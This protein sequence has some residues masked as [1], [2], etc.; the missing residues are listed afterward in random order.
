MNWTELVHCCESPG[1]IQ[2]FTKSLFERRLQKGLCDSC[3]HAKHKV[4]ENCLK[5]NAVLFLSTWW[6]SRWS[7]QFKFIM[8][9]STFI[10]WSDT[11]SSCDE[12]YMME[13]HLWIQKT[14]TLTASYTYRCPFPYLSRKLKDIEIKWTNEIP[15]WNYHSIKIHEGPLRGREKQTW[16]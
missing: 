14:F 16:A 2:W 10:Q 1:S 6:C 11:V 4:L 13:S 7:R 3:S 8:S 15:T 9:T 12:Q 5:V